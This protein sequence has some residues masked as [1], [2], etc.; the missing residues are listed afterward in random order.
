MSCWAWNWAV[1]A[2]RLQSYMQIKQ[3]SPKSASARQRDGNQEQ[4]EGKNCRF[5]AVLNDVRAEPS[6]FRRNKAGKMAEAQPWSSAITSLVPNNRAA[7]DLLI[8]AHF[9]P[10]PFSI[11]DTRRSTSI[12]TGKSRSNSPPPER[13]PPLR[14]TCTKRGRQ[15]GEGEQNISLQNFVSVCVE[16]WNRECLWNTAAC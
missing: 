4:E 3:L 16:R 8:Q 9:S 6:P 13:R 11:L 12:L 14:T 5:A 10:L 15:G 2:F 1:K 7:A